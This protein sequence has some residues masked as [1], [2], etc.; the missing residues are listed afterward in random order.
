[1]A[2]H[3]P[4]PSAPNLTVALVSGTPSVVPRDT[5]LLF[6]ALAQV[7]QDK[8][9]DNDLTMDL[10]YTKEALVKM[11]TNSVLVELCPPLGGTPRMTRMFTLP[12][13]G[14][15]GVFERP[16]A[17]REPPP[18]ERAAPTFSAEPPTAPA[19]APQNS[20]TATNPPAPAP[21]AAPPTGFWTPATQPA[22]AAHPNITPPTPPLAPNPPPA[23]PTARFW[24]PSAT[25]GPNQEL[26]AIPQNRPCVQPPQR[27][28]NNP[29]CDVRLDLTGTLA[30]K[31]TENGR[32][33]QRFCAQHNYPSR[34]R[35][36][37]A[38]AQ[39]GATDHEANPRD[40]ADGSLRAAA[41]AAPREQENALRA[42]A[43]AAPREQENALRAAAAAAPRE[44]E[45]GRRAVQGG[46][47]ESPRAAARL[48]AS[49]QPPGVSGGSAS[50]ALAPA[51]NSNTRAKTARAASAGGE[52]VAAASTSSPYQNTRA[53]TQLAA[54]TQ[55]LAVAFAAQE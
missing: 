25:S 44:Q 50:A 12:S 19:L 18:L 9:D 23:A 1:V 11:L 26:Q 48:A 31:I 46:G 42:A 13:G 43:A 3:D 15:L 49:T 32:A 8:P 29:D 55:L 7:T 6:T 17:E 51:S 20:P 53:A 16:P 38:R 45:N 28:C 35:D 10:K 36:A 40:T 33:P 2:S 24:P 39:G 52:P 54:P 5:S 14:Y 27:L 22:A 34:R 47:N 4:G 37:A 41:A 30:K 21:P